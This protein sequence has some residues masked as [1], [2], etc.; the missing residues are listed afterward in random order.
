VCSAYLLVIIQGVPSTNMLCPDPLLLA[1]PACTAI[2][3]LAVSKSPK[4]DQKTVQLSCVYVCSAYLLFIIPGALSTAMTCPDPLLLAEPVC[5]AISTSY[6]AL[7]YQK[8]QKLTKKRYSCHACMCGQPSCWSSFQVLSALICFVLILC[9]SPSLF[10]PR[11]QP[12]T[13][14]CGIQK[15]KK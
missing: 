12:L 1:E 5:A 14:P 3:T 4:I 10:V 7:G 13:W 6:M 9:C 11:Y 15:P 2:S 8:A